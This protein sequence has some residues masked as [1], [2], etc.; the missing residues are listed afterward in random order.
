MTE[1][2]MNLEKATESTLAKAV[3]RFVV[4]VFVAVIGFLGAWALQDIRANQQEQ[5]KLQLVQSREIQQVSS[6]LQVLKATV[7]SGLVW[8]IT[9]IERRLNQV[10]R[11]TAVRPQ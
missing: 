7:D 9:D 8:R 10:E 11:N 5:A 2:D 1:H 3:T 4:P 6:D